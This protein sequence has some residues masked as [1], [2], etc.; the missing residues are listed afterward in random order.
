MIGLLCLLED[1]MGCD[2]WIA[3]CKANWVPASFW[4]WFIIGILITASLST[5]I[6]GLLTYKKEN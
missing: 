6:L 2:A 1:L 3:F 4:T 5:L